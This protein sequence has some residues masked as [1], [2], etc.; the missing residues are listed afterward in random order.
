LTGTGLKANVYVAYMH[1]LHSN[2]QN[3]MGQIKGAYTIG[4]P[5]GRAS[6]RERIP[7]AVRSRQMW[8]FKWVLIVPNGNN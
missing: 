1:S 6:E 4:V 5:W 7:P 8:L 2:D 3:D